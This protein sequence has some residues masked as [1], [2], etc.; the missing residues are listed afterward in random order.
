MVAL[1]QTIRRP[2]CESGRRL[3]ARLA[4]KV[5]WRR[6]CKLP[7]DQLVCDST[8]KNAAKEG[9]SDPFPNG[10]I[11]HPLSIQGDSGFGAPACHFLGSRGA[12]SLTTEH[13]LDDIQNVN[14][15]YLLLIQRLIN[16]DREMAVFR[17]KM[18]ESMAD[19]LG[20]MPVTDLSRLARCNQLLCN[21]S[22]N[23][24]DEL[25][26]LVNSAK[27]EDFLQLH[28]AILLSGQEAREGESHDG[29]SQNS[30]SSSRSSDVHGQESLC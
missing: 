22:L 24:A 16:T 18:D 25:Y 27:N 9:C 29:E 14:L 10:A 1:T 30:K 23:S 7:G 15:S 19:L 11:A 8:N 3:H 17:L 28:A 20:S 13:L 21:F 12:T 5:P 26:A 2:L 6:S 4:A